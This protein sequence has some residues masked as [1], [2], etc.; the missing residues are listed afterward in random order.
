MRG[1][2]FQSSPNMNMSAVGAGAAQPASSPACCSDNNSMMIATRSG[3]A[4]QAHAWREAQHGGDHYQQ[5]CQEVARGSHGVVNS[6]HCFAMHDQNAP[7]HSRK[8][9]RS[10]EHNSSDVTKIMEPCENHFVFQLH[11][12]LCL[13]CPTSTFVAF[14]YIYK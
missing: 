12:L 6:E 1:I 10:T 2:A 14:H 3:A 7:K 11:H 8:S 13:P 4:Q 9:A 5:C